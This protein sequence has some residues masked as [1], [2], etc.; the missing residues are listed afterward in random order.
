VDLS[1]AGMA[2]AELANVRKNAALALRAPVK[3]LGPGASA[4][5]ADLVSL[6]FTD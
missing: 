2:E 4:G 5:G 1:F 3:L 6:C